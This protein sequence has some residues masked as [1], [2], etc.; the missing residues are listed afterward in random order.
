MKFTIPVQD[1]AIELAQEHGLKFTVNTTADEVRTATSVCIEPMNH[2]QEH[3]F[4][5]IPEFNIYAIKFHHRTDWETPNAFRWDPSTN[6]MVDCHSEEFAAKYAQEYAEITAA[7]KAAKEA[8]FD[9]KYRNVE[10]V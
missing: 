10:M 9:R 3:A 4:G 6:R 8:D 1:R 5:E 7:N 2:Y